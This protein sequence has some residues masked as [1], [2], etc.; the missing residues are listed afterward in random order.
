MYI[1]HVFKNRENVYLKYVL[2][3]V[4]YKQNYELTYGNRCNI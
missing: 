2:D 4:R 1:L 3:I